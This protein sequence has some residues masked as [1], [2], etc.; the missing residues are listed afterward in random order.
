MHL[1]A[2]AIDYDDGA[3]QRSFLAQWPA[4]SDAHASYWSRISG[5]TDIASTMR[6]VSNPYRSRL[7]R[8]LAIIGGTGLYDLAGMQVQHELSADTPFGRASGAGAAR[9]LHGRELLFLARHGAGHQL[10]PH[11]VNYRANVFALKR[12]GATQILGFSAVGSLAEAR[13]ARRLGDAIAILRLDQGG[14]RAQL[15]SVAAWRRT[16]PP[17]C[18]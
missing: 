3:W 12:A 11:E 9:R 2:I 6:C 8:M 5:G 15:S 17:R 10:L 7:N 4:G 18:Q 1:D 16:Y 13:R 14:A